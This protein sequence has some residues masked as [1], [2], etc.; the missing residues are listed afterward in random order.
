MEYKLPIYDISIDENFEL[1]VDTVGLVSKPAMEGEWV[2]LAEQEQIKLAQVEDQQL[3]IGAALIPDKLIYRYN[4]KTKEEYYI[5][6]SKETIKKIVD[7]YFKKGNQINFN[8][9]HNALLDVNATVNESWIIED[10]AIDK[11]ALYGFNYPVGTWMLSVH[12]EDKAYWDEFVK[13]GLIKGFSIE[14]GFA[15]ELVELN[16]TE[17]IEPKSGESE[18]EFVS[19]C[20]A[21]HVGTEGMDTEQAAAICYTKFKGSDVELAES[22]SDY[23]QTASDNAQRALNYAEENGW[24]SCGTAVGKQRANQLAKREPISE[25]TIARMASFERHRQNS[26]TPYGE[27]CGKLMWDA[28]GGDEGIAWAQSKL[29]EIQKLRIGEKIGYDYDNVLTTRAGKE[30]VRKDIRDNSTIF[31]VSARSDKSGMLAVA[32]Q[33]GIP[34]SRVYATGSNNAKVNKVRELGLIRFYDNN[35]VVIRQLPRVGVAFSL[36]AEEIEELLKE[37]LRNAN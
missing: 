19:R 30:M 4:D 24:G 14:G 2:A 25:E 31:I 32:N 15:Q 29:D 8:L 23:P 17:L 6:F 5:K 10:S 28:W 3:L 22:Y 1:G 12:V 37:I 21:Y 9:E 7:R 11:S 13:T 35:R 16:K 20:I 36:T 18:D 26:T 34:E 27:G 33:L